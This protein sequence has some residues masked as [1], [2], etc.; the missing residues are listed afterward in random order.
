MESAYDGDEEEEE[1]E[2]SNW[3][4]LQKLCHEIEQIIINMT[5]PPLSWYLERYDM[6]LIYSRLEWSA[7]AKHCG[8]YD[9]YIV[10]TS[11]IIIDNIE[12]LLDEFHQTGKFHLRFYQIMLQDINNL[13]RYYTETYIGEERDPDIGDLIMS[14]THKL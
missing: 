7:F 11:L 4:K 3:D 9:N 10:D 5:D 2:E 14:L 12:Y 6:I 8:E 13:W 1:V